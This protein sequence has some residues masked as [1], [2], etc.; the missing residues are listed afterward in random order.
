MSQKHEI[1]SESLL[2]SGVKK[3]EKWPK[4][5]FLQN[6][7]MM[8]QKVHRDLLGNKMSSLH[9]FIPLDVLCVTSFMNSWV[10]DKNMLCEVAETFLPPKSSRFTTEQK[11]FLSQTWRKISQNISEI[12]CSW[13]TGWTD[14]RTGIIKT[15]FT[16]MEAFKRLETRANQQIKETL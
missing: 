8:S 11:L 12:L 14:G 16:C 9:G 4:S 6:I 10:M 5:V 2:C 7:I 15:F 3:S 13:R 1:R